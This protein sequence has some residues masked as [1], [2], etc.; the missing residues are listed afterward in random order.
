MELLM[1]MRLRDQRAV[2]VTVGWSDVVGF[3]VVG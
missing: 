2:A 3:E 1:R